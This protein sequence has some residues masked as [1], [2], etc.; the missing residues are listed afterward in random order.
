MSVD[1]ASIPQ[2]VVDAYA[3]AELDHRA[4]R[5]TSDALRRIA[6]AAALDALIADDEVITVWN[7]FR[8]RAWARPSTVVDAL[9]AQNPA[10]TKQDNAPT[11]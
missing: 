11:T 9:L 5:I 1:P 4:D 3:I 6:L 2:H 10:P 7:S 8:S